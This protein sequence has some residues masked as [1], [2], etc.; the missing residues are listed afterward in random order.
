MLLAVTLVS[1]CAA[2]TAKKPV[3]PNDDT[4]FYL[5]RYDEV[6]DATLAALRKESIVIDSMNKDR[7][8][9]STKFVNYSSGPQA[10]YEI[11]SIAARPSDVR[12]ALW[13]QVGYTLNILVTP[14][15]DMSTKVKV[16][17]HIEAYDKNVSQEWHEC[18]SNKTVENGFIEK[19]RAQL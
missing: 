18:P 17:A 2:A 15:N 3:K 14:M 11:D 5:A 9:I 1:G 8:V 16:I 12:L 6:W 19:I 7:G 10:H 13:S 4:A